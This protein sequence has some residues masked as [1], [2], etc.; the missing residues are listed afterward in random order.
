MPIMRERLA[1]DDIIFSPDMGEPEN[2]GAK[3]LYIE[4]GVTDLPPG[5]NY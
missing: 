4:K 2:K 3:F 1:W 5:W